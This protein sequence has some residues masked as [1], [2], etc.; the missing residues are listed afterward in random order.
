MAQIIKLAFNPFQENTY[1]V[2][3]ESGECVIFDPGCYTREEQQLLVNEISRKKLRPV[4]LINTHCHIDHVFGNQFVHEHYGLPLEIHRDELPVLQAAPQSA[5]F[6][7]LPIPNGKLSPEPER[8]IEDGQV[9]SF[10]N[11]RLE[12]IFTPGHAPGE[13]C[14]FC[15]ESRFLIAGDVLFFGS[16]GRTDLPGGNHNTLIDS[17]INRVFPLGDDVTVYPGHGPDTSIGYER[18][19]NPFVGG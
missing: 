14:F 3:D 17:I 2:Y 16:I 13:L 12:A 1:V 18:R 19:H 10:G 9:V 11:T 4:R 8:F 15:E 6:F 5:L 7:G